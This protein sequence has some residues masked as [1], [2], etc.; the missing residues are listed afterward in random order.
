MAAV[1]WILGRLGAAVFV[2][3]VVATL[4]FFALR[5][6]GGDPLQAILG[7]PGSQ[8]SPEAV[9]AARDAYGLDE[10]IIVQYLIQL[11]RVATFNLGQSYSRRQ[12]VEELIAANLADTLILAITALVLAWALALAGAMIA[13]SVSGRLGRLVSTA[14]RGIEVLASVMP[15]FWLGA[16]L[17]TVFA[18]NLGIVPATSA[19]S[20]PRSLALP[21]ITLAIP[22]AGFLGQ[23]MRDGLLEAHTS[24]FA[25]TAR[26]RGATEQRVLLRHSLRHASLPAI[27]LTGWAFGSLLSGAVVVE[28]LFGRPGLGRLML[29]ATTDRDVPVVIGSVLVVALGYV[30]V[31]TL[32]DLA[33]ILIDPRNRGSRR[34]TP[35]GTDA[36]VVS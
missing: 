21:A 6:S 24:P 8:A 9:Q 27:A 13:V 35:P 30:L 17:I 23:V 28:S 29:A 14:L 19:S 34:R 5:A 2:T 20:A 15:H 4:V 10:P 32:A 22:I 16:I 36:V 31:M 1:R 25:T 26:S 3:W 18:V 12:P 11:Q 33:E 7:G